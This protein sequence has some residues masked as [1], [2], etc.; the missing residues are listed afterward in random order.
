M[1]LLTA[2]AGT[3]GLCNE[4]QCGVEQWVHCSQANDALRGFVA[5]IPT[6]DDLSD[7][8]VVESCGIQSVGV[9]SFL[10]L[11]STT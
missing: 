4:R 3:T 5:V 2:G 6:T 8:W 9:I 10:H 7:P 1:V 11:L